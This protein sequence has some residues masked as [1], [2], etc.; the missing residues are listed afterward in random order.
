[1]WAHSAQT[2]F[3]VVL[4]P[5][6][7]CQDLVPETASVTHAMAGPAP[8][9]LCLHSTI[10]PRPGEQSS[11]LTSFP[12]QFRSTMTPAGSTKRST[13]RDPAVNSVSSNSGVN[14]TSVGKLAA[15]YPSWRHATVGPCERKTL[16]TWCQEP[17]MK[18][19]GCPITHSPSV[20]WL[21]SRASP[22]TAARQICTGQPQQIH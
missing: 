12:L 6:T 2:S 21:T 20:C 22:S 9:G 1:M 13:A 14:S 16:Q 15:P 5:W 10:R 3:R 18:I 8:E 4:A 17:K 7:A 11:R 19:S